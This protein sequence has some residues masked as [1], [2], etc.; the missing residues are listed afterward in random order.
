MLNGRLGI[1]LVNTSGPHE[2]APLGGI[3][4]IAPVGPLTVAISLAREPRSIVQQP[5]GKKL[6]VTWKNGRASV[7]LPSLEIY[8]ILVVE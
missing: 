5:E 6:D 2:K 7:T 4:E 3:E 1:H 8:S